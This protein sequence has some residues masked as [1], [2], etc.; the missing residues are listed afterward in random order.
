MLKFLGFLILTP[1]I[2]LSVTIYV[3]SYLSSNDN[4]QPPTHPFFSRINKVEIIAHRGGA[5]EVPENTHMAFSYIQKKFPEAIIEFDVRMT[6]D[7]RLVVIHDETL[8][9]TTNGT[10]K[11]SQSSLN[12][13]QAL[14]AGYNFELGG[15]FP[16]RDIAYNRLRIPLVSDVFKQYNNRLIL[17]IKG[18]RD[19]QLEIVKQ[20][21]ALIDKLKQDAE[22]GVYRFN[23]SISRNISGLSNRLVISS[24]LFSPIYFARNKKPDWLY[25]PTRPEVYFKLIPLNILG[26]VKADVKI[27]QILKLKSDVYCLPKTYEQ[28]DIVDRS[29]INELKRIKKPLFVWTINDVQEMESLIQMGVD[30]IITDRPSELSKILTRLS[31]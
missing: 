9:R 6:S 12:E 16:Y 5:L 18:N 19:Q 20:L 7:N 14:N 8:D 11:I 23:P 28:R 3:L 25:A 24:E 17:E 26:V 22:N 13:I 15:L 30:G 2:V 1:F 27:N 31:K 29:L 4:F 10:G 21:I